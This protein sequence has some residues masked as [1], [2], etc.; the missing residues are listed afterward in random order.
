MQNKADLTIVEK[1]KWIENRKAEK[2][3]SV[4][5]NVADMPSSLQSNTKVAHSAHTHI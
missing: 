4:S 2:Q 1:Q 5:Q 3:L